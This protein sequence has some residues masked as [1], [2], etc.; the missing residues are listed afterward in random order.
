MRNPKALRIP[1]KDWGR[2][3]GSPL[4]LKSPSS[5]KKVSNISCQVVGHYT[6]K[7]PGDSRDFPIF[8]GTFS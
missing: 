2:L 7:K 3:G 8:F 6:P 5:P 4:R 1:R